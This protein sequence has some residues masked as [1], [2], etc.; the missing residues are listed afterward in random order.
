M[1]FILAVAN[2]KGGTGKSTIAVSLA[3]STVYDTVA[4]GKRSR[5]A[6]EEEVRRKPTDPI[7]VDTDSQGNATTWALGGAADE[8]VAPGRS[9]A[10]LT[11]P[12]DRRL[13]S[14]TDP[15]AL[16]KTPDEVVEI[17][18]PLALR[19]VPEFPRLGL[20]P[21]TPR[22][23]PEQSARL[24][25]RELPAEIVVVD[26]GS[27]CSTPL[28]RSVLAQ[29]D[30]IVVPTLC[31]P[32]STDGCSNVFE[33]IVTAGRG[34]LIESGRVRVVINR[35]ERNKTHDV[36]EQTLRKHLGGL[37][38]DVVIPKAAPIGLVSAGAGAIT[39]RHKI[40]PLAAALWDD[41]LSRLERKVA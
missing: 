23:H 16:A 34:D 41:I 11:F 17:G 20:I 38:S 4:P 2:R 27:D 18:L 26:T 30:A 37:V 3:V 32:W 5:K 22:H 29:A 36:L 21:A 28:V 8:L 1:P 35:R 31:E 9:V 25:L 14:S 7:L 39:P 33:E 40:L 12:I 19:T 15:L 10:S 13:V 24:C 6:P